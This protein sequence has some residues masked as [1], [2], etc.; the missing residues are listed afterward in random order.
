MKELLKTYEIVKGEIKNRLIEFNSIW[1]NRKKK[2]ILLELI[3]C[4]LTPQSRAK[5]CWEVVKR[6]EKENMYFDKN[7]VEKMLMGVRFRRKKAKY[8]V[9]AFNLFKNIDMIDVL[10]SMGNEFKAREWV[11]KNVKGIGYKEASH[12]LRNIGFSKNLAILDRHVLRNLKRFGVIDKIPS[13]LSRK[14]YIE[15]E[16]KFAN[17]SKKLGIEVNELDLLIWYIETGEIFK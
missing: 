5:I 7:K 10:E 4:I 15:I 11:I 1:K 12:F 13:A 14:K 17:L 8:V 3:F 6:I 16:K 9:D 2:D